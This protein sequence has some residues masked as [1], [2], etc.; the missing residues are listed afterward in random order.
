MMASS[1]IAYQEGEKWT[2]Y[3]KLMVGGF[4]NYFLANHIKSVFD[5]ANS[6]FD[7][8]EFSGSEKTIE[9]SQ[10]DTLCGNILG[11]FFFGP[12]FNNRTCWGN[13][14]GAVPIQL[15]RLLKDQQL[16]DFIPLFG[17]SIINFGLTKAHSEIKKLIRGSKAEVRGVL[18]DC[19]KQGNL[20]KTSFVYMLLE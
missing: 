4:N 1:A 3:R 6:F 19:R 11:N 12:A 10:M 9:L 18:E 2:G 17:P 20:D 16:K 13:P 5:Q 15:H 14:L 7:N 8:F